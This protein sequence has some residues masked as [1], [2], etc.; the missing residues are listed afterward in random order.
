M[1]HDARAA[2]V[3]FKPE[4]VDTYEVGVKSSFRGAISGV[5]N[6]TAYYNN[7]SNQQL[8]VGLN[9]PPGSGL[10]PTAAPYN[11]GKSRIWGIE[12]DTTLNLFQGFSD[13]KRVVSGKRGEVRVDLGGGR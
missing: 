6:A 2:M 10:S 13:R 12:A 4:K 7:F 1:K 5:F 8:L 3:F 9:A 11:A